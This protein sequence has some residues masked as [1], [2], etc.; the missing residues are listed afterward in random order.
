MC[1]IQPNST[2]YCPVVTADLQQYGPIWSLL[3]VHM[4]WNVLQ[5]DCYLRVLY[6]HIYSIDQNI[7]IQTIFA[8]IS[9]FEH[10]LQW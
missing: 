7:K 10:P 8:F 5:F 2:F 1:I 3:A 6:D 4:E 9:V